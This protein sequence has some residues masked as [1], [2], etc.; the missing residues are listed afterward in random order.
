MADHPLLGAVLFAIGA[1]LVGAAYY[2]LNVQSLVL[3]HIIAFNGVLLVALGCH[4][5][6]LQ[7]GNAIGALRVFNGAVFIES[8]TPSS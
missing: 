2:S 6:N 3:G 5:L 8:N 7:S 4:K 1:V